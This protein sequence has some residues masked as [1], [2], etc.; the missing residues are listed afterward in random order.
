[1]VGG[2]YEPDWVYKAYVAGKKKASRADYYF[3]TVS[4]E[5]NEIWE[6]VDTVIVFAVA[7]LEKLEV[8]NKNV[9]YL[10]KED[11]YR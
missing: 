5:F 11:I 3:E 9:I 7:D 8:K 1:M 10:G 4:G 6:E 2:V